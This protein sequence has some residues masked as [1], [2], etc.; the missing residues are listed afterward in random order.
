[1]IQP[2]MR[3]K[4]VIIVAIATQEIIV[5]VF[6]TQ[7]HILK[8]IHGLCTRKHRSD[9]DNGATQLDACSSCT[10]PQLDRRFG[11]NTQ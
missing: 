9:C 2:L 3:C 8:D 6:Q 5:V 4:I 11:Q 7:G 1:M 10:L